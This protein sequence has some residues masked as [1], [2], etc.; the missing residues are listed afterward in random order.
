MNMDPIDR[1][2]MRK[3]SGQYNFKRQGQPQEH[4]L[5]ILVLKWGNVRIIQRK[6]AFHKILSRSILDTG[7]IQRVQ[8]RRT[9]PDVRTHKNLWRRKRT[10]RQPS[11]HAQ[12]PAI[13][14]GGRGNPD[15]RWQ[16]A[17]VRMPFAH[18]RRSDSSLR[19]LMDIFLWQII[20]GCQHRQCWSQ[21]ARLLFLLHARWWEEQNMRKNAAMMMARS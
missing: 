17:Q 9:M 20:V 21:P 19:Y 14:T 10:H 1:L 8:Y 7:G 4:V 15:E 6:Y 16:L 3:S 2:G 13:D 5:S 11:T 18:P 12:T